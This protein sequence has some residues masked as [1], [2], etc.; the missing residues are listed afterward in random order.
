MAKPWPAITIAQQSAEDA[1]NT[2]LAR[3]GCS[4]P[5]RDS[6]D[7][8][9]IE[10][11]RNGTA[12]YGNGIISSPNDVGGWPEL[13]SGTAPA[14]SDQDG[15][16]D[17]WEVAHGLD[18]SMAADRNGTNLSGTYYTNLEVYLNGLVGDSGARR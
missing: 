15:M 3:A 17:A 6:V 18:P 8:R 13:K 11:V 2:V 16:P 1:Y 10:E 14:D 4:L 9:I 7:A 12:T 5:K